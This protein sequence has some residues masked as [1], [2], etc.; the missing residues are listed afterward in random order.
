MI[1][2]GEQRLG[3]L[4][5]AVEHQDAPT[6]FALW[7]QIEEHDDLPYRST[8]EELDESFVTQWT[9]LAENS[10]GGF[11]AGGRLCAFG[12]VS[13]SPGEQG[14]VRV[15]LDGGVRPDYRHRGVGSTVLEWQIER[16]RQILADDDHGTG[17]IVVHVEEEMSHTADLVRRYGFTEAGYHTEMR[18]D[19]SLELP[20]VSVQRPLSVEP[21]SAELDE[22]VRLAHNESSSGQAP[23]QSATL[24]AEGRTYFVPEWSFLVLDRTSDR[25][26]VAGYLLS[27]RY[28][29]DWA[30]LGWSEGYVDMLGVRAPWRGQRIATTLLVRAMSAFAASGMEFAALG[31][32]HA[33]RQDS[34]G[35][36]GKLGFEPTRG[37]T[38]YTIEL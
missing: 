13:V 19:L 33:T 10:I 25:A 30:T 27:S 20:D 18:R 34:L 38:T 9:D 36:F 22:Q 21:W 28:E 37:S 8:R 29:Q 31:V 16:A 14:P 11:D 1:G 3:L 6:L 32:D 2:A 7:Q 26:Q 4:W 15:F 35:L 12:L 23:A 5:R 17:T 24:W